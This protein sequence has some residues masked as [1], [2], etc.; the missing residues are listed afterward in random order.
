MAVIMGIIQIAMQLLTC[1]MYIMVLATDLNSAC[2]G[3]TECVL[4]NG[5]PNSICSTNSVW[6]TEYIEN[7]GTCAKDTLPYNMYFYIKFMSSNI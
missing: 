7:G 2:N 6:N 3:N 4:G 1:V 5:G